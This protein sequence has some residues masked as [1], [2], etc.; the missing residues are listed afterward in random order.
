[1][2]LNTSSRPA[3][4]F[5]ILSLILSPLGLL[6]VIFFAIIPEASQILKPRF[7]Q[8]LL[9]ALLAV[10]L[11]SS[12]VGIVRKERSKLSVYGLA[13]TLGIIGLLALFFNSLED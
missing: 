1:M 3:P 2:T 9:F 8:G 13:T 11:C 12:I 7:A 10:G 5:G 6:V 4:L